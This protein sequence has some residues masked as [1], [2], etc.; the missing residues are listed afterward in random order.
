MVT[1]KQ[2]GSRVISAELQIDGV[3]EMVELWVVEDS[4]HKYD[5]LMTNFYRSLECKSYQN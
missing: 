2:Y 4:T 3:P 1:Q 5:L